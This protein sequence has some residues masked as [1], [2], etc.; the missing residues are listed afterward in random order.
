[1][2]T[3]IKI[4]NKELKEY[5]ASDELN[6]PLSGF[7]QLLVV[8][9]NNEEFVLNG[10]TVDVT[11]V[12]LNNIQYRKEV[13]DNILY[14]YAKKKLKYT[15]DNRIRLSVSMYDLDCGP[16]SSEEVPKNEIWLEE[17]WLK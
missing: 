7:Y 16:V 1:M 13:I 11:K 10:K 9:T 2:T 14:K 17:G 12:K 3:I 4:K 8:L 15:N 5:F 6:D